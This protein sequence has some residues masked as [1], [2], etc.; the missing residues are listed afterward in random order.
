MIKKNYIIS[1]IIILILALLTS[2]L[3][4]Y[5]KTDNRYV[6]FFSGAGMRVPASEIVNSFTH[7]TGISVNVHFNWSSIL[8]RSIEVFGNADVFLSG[9]KRNIDILADKG[10]VKESSFIAWHIPAILVPPEKW[11]SIK[12]LNDLAREGVRFVMSNPKLAASGRL[13]SEA[14]SKHPKAADILKNVV[15][16]GASTDDTLKLFNELYK[17]GEADAVIEWHEMIYTP[18]GNGLLSVP[19]EKEY[20]IRDQIIIALLNSSNNPRIS[21]KFYDYFKTNASDIFKKYGYNTEAE[22]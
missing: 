16:Y 12:G 2:S 15:I 5:K 13:A 14:I 8:R 7:T 4:L 19:F 3:Y 21:K 17:K 9:D 18:E 1:C 6:I 11:E 10:L 22:K 20:Q